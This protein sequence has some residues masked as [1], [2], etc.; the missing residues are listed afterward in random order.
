V[1]SAGCRGFPCYSRVCPGL[2]RAVV[3]AE[4]VK[5]RKTVE[6]SPVI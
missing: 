1:L 4:T 2:R 5:N 3:V 6:W